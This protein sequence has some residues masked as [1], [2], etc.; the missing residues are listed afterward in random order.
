[1]Y[2]KKKNVCIHIY[3]YEDEDEVSSANITKML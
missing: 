3:L 2:I 1:M